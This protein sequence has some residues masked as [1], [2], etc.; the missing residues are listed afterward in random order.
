[1]SVVDA[2]ASTAVDVTV[3]VVKATGKAMVKVVDV[4]TPEA[5]D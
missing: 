5:K 1:M 2:V 3:G 4:V